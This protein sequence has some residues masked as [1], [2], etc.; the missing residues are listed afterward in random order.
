MSHQELKLVFMHLLQYSTLSVYYIEDYNTN[1]HIEI[2]K[3][4]HLPAIFPSR[5][6]QNNPNIVTEEKRKGKRGNEQRNE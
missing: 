6:C 1:I 2:H 5:C 3:L 4:P